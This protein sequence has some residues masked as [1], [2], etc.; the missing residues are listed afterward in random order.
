MSCI[1]ACVTKSIPYSCIPATDEE[2]LEDL[3]KGVGDKIDHPCILVVG[4]ER[5]VDE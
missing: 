3:G 2:E 4:S 5:H 1:H